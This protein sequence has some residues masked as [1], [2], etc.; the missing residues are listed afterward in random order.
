MYVDT[1]SLAFMLS[2]LGLLTIYS[3]LRRTV[4]VCN[5]CRT[6]SDGVRL[7][8]VR[9]PNLLPLTIHVLRI[10]F[11]G[12]RVLSY[13]SY[14]ML[15]RLSWKY[16]RCQWQYEAQRRSCKQRQLCS[17]DIRYQSTR[18][19]HSQATSLNCQQTGHFVAVCWYDWTLQFPWI[20]KTRSGF[21]F[22]LTD[23]F[24]S[25]AWVSYHQSR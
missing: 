15:C 10:M 24:K 21:S 14:E 16:F 19:V 1:I 22:G 25:S 2:A 7:R 8:C 6:N 5:S 18:H 9:I 12:S 17:V 3:V 13:L 11:F 20:V 23:A 4:S